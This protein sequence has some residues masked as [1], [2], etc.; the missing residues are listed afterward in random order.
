MTQVEEGSVM[1]G[2]RWKMC[3]ADQMEFLALI[4]MSLD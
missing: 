2:L 4:R 1:V 3:F